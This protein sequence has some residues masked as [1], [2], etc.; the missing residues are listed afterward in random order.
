LNIRFIPRNL[1]K[2]QAYLRSLP[3]GVSDAA[4][5]AYTTY[6]VG[7]QAHGLKHYSPYRYIPIKRAGGFKSDRQRRFVMAKIREGTIDPG[8]P[9]RTGKGQRGWTITKTSRGYTIKNSETSMI[10]SMDDAR[11]ATLNRLAGWRK[12]SQSIQ[13]NHAGAM[14]SANAAVRAFLAK[15]G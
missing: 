1:E 9:H 6:Q 14:R 10:Y 7:T 13:D 3:K 15:K 8:V 5:K 4:L 12:V 11:Q 2:V